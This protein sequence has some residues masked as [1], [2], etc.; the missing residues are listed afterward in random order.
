[1]LVDLLCL[2]LMLFNQGK[3]FNLTHVELYRI[4]WANIIDIVE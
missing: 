3:G 2:R 1:M 4:L